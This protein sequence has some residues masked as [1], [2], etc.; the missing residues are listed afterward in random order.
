MVT[1]AAMRDFP[2]TASY[3]QS[4]SALPAGIVR[5]PG[6]LTA[7]DFTVQNPM[8]MKAVDTLLY[9]TVMDMRRGMDPAGTLYVLI[10]EAH[11]FSAHRMAQTGLMASL[12]SESSSLHSVFTTEISYN[13]L[14][15]SLEQE[16]RRELR[17]E[18]TPERKERLREM[19]PI[20]H[21]DARAHMSGSHLG[22]APCA[23]DR[24]FQTALDTGTPVIP[25][26]ASKQSA[27]HIDPGDPLAQAFAAQ[28]GIDLTRQKIKIDS[29]AGVNIRNGVMAHRT[30]EAADKYSADIM[31]SGVGRDHLG[32][33]AAGLSFADSLPAHI[34]DATSPHD[35]IL[36]IYF[37]APS[38][39]DEDIRPSGS[40][41]KVTPMI[42]RGVAP[43][44]YSGKNSYKAENNFIAQL[45]KS[46]KGNVP[47][48]FRSSPP[49]DK[50]EVFLSH[51]DDIMP[52]VLN[53]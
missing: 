52:Y 31:V 4:Y 6:G 8:D 21:L 3:G 13:F 7:L 22:Y 36:T 39:N 24:F 23:M 42:L 17:Q 29:N 11:K 27:S 50:E 2:D 16:I 44:M 51:M 30:I 43:A 38:E 37:T 20:G 32:D 40:H 1:I 26:D 15:Q 19:N 28:A 35:K 49:P 14:E 33:T 10:G 48:R 34:A 12:A 45:G 41:S 47:E 46:Y 53:G 25:V 9:Q 5:T 18:M